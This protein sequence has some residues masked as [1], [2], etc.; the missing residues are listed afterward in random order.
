MLP[1]MAQTNAVRLAQALQTPYLTFKD[2]DHKGVTGEEM[3]AMGLLDES[4]LPRT[5]FTVFRFCME[6]YKGRIICGCVQRQEGNL[7][8]VAFHR[9]EGK[10]GPVSWAITFKRWAANGDMEYDGRLFDTNTL[11]DVTE[12]VK[13]VDATNKANPSLEGMTPERAK[14]LIP[15]LVSQV[16]DLEKS[17]SILRGQSDMLTSLS[18]IVGKHE[19]PIGAPSVFLTLY[20]SVMLL[21]YEYLAP[22]N[23]VARVIPSAQGKSVEWVR[24]R[25]HYTVIHRHHAAN[26]KAVSEGATVTDSKHTIRLAHSRRAHTRI[27]THPK[28]TFKRG[29]R[30]FVRASWVGPK[31]WKDTAGQ[32]YQI[33]T[34]VSP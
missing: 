26:N 34:A 25:E 8:L 7:Q 5:P 20:H 22:H 16:N 24:A 21:C 23:F 1:V 2:S 30:V 3:R 15:E 19:A 18:S 17:V 33:L 29:Q 14:K 11:K 10:I 28:W 12:F 9:Y 6:D 4:G 27:L 31:E 32:T 13:Q